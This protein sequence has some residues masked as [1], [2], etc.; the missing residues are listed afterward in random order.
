VVLAGAR[1]LTLRLEDGRR[2]AFTL[3]SSSGR[4]QVQ[5]GFLTSDS[6]D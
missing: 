4:I 2:L 1:D 6:A 5:G 3:T